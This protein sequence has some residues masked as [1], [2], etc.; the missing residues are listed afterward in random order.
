ME[1][2]LA[3]GLDAVPKALGCIYGALREHA[4][5]RSLLERAFHSQPQTLSRLN[6]AR[7]PLAARPKN[8]KESREKARAREKR[9]RE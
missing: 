1:S 5:L 9:E 7:T 8:D 6:T 2:R 4:G 3:T